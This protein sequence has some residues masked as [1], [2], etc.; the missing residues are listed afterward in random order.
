MNRINNINNAINSTKIS[1]NLNVSSEINFPQG[2]ILNAQ[3]IE[4]RSDGEAIL[5]IGNH[6]VKAKMP[7]N[8]FVRPGDSFRIQVIGKE[9]DTWNFKFISINRSSIFYKISPEIVNSYLISMKLPITD[10]SLEIAKALFKYNLPLNAENYRSLLPFSSQSSK[11]Y[12][13]AAAFLKSINITPNI[14]NVKIMYEFLNSNQLLANILYSIYSYLTSNPSSVNPIIFG[15]IQALISNILR[16]DNRKEG[17]KISNLNGLVSKELKGILTRLDK[18]INLLQDGPLKN[19]LE[20]LSSILKAIGIINSS[21][22]EEKVF[23]NIIPAII[24]GYPTTV[25]LKIFYYVDKEL[26]KVERNRFSFEITV[27]APRIGAVTISGSVFENNVS[28]HI[29]KSLLPEE[30]FMNKKYLLEELINKTGYKLG[31]FIVKYISEI[32]ID[33]GVDFIT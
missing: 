4:R 3:L 20:K 2:R 5:K 14:S 32:N 7:Q 13:E 29:K 28:A 16:E 31:N 30:V 8:V 12:L 11:L 21:L 23:F 19:N 9:K 15:I 18:A 25:E 27:N 6:S 26:K 24:N 22:Q 17:N 1:G 33:E 10:N